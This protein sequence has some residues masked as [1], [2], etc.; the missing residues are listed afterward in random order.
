MS[1]VH[2]EKFYYDEKNQKCL[3]L[4]NFLAVEHKKKYV[5]VYNNDGVLI[6]HA[7]SWRRAS[8]IAKLL[9]QAYQDGYSRG[10]EE[11]EDWFRY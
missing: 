2:Y 10:Y 7:A 11:A 9:D 8:K 6:T 3:Q 1:L 5:S 4:G